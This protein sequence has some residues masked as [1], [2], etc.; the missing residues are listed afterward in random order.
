MAKLRVAKSFLDLIK[1]TNIS[2]EQQLTSKKEDKK[3][4]TSNIFVG[5]YDDN[6][7]D[8]FVAGDYEYVERLTHGDY[9]EKHRQSGTVLKGFTSNR[10]AIFWKKHCRRVLASH[11]ENQ[12]ANVGSCARVRGIRYTAD[13][14]ITQII[15]FESVRNSIFSGAKI[16]PYELGKTTTS[17]M[18]EVLKYAPEYFGLTQEQ[19]KTK[20]KV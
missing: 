16:R 8:L 14:N 6:C 9:M 12:W 2:L 15:N 13:C 11:I 4:D 19:D 7:V 5:V 10:I 3:F 1:G 17:E 18:L 20:Q